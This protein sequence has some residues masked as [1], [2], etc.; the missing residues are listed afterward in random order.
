MAFTL[1]VELA[2]GDVVVEL[3]TDVEG[4]AVRLEIERRVH[5]LLLATG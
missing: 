5:T 2:G 3:P 4:D 1:E